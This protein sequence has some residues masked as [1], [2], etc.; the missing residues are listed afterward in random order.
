MSV[1]DGSSPH[2]FE[3]IASGANLQIKIGDPDVFV[4]GQ[5][6][7]RIQYTLLDALNPNP[8][9]ED[10]V[11]QPWD[12]FFWNVTGDDSAATILKASAIVRL[13]SAEIEQITC[14]QGPTGSRDACASAETGDSATFQATTWLG[15]GSELTIVTAIEKG[16][17]DVGPPV[18]VDPQESDWQRFADLWNFG[19]LALA[20]T[21]LIG[22][23]AIIA[24]AR[25]WWLEGRDRWHGDLCTTCSDGDEFSSENAKAASCQRNDSGRVPASNDLAAEWPAT[26]PG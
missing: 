21:A 25:L 24:L 4:T 2:E 22:V 18:L 15:P 5:Q 16:A 13:P 8:L 1:D 17:V 6:R 7:Y 26:T 11:P 14:Y 9:N 23:V 19:P 3:L 10:G 20:A 12:E